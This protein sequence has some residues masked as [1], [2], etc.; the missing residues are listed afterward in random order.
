MWKYI[1]FQLWEFMGGPLRPDRDWKPADSR[2][3]AGGAEGWELVA[4][5]PRHD[6]NARD[7]TTYVAYMKRPIAG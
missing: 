1:A 4:V 3:D 5:V 6:A 7:G 2:N